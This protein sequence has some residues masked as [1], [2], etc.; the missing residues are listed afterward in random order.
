[1]RKRDAGIRGRDIVGYI[2]YGRTYPNGPI[3]DTKVE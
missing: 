1:M 2:E 3:G